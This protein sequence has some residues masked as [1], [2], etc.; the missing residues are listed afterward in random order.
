MNTD[1]KFYK[2]L[3][4]LDKGDLGQGE[5]LLNEIVLESEKEGDYINLIRGLV[6][7]ADFQ[8]SQGKFIEARNL[9]NKVINSSNIDL[10]DLLDFEH[11]RA[12]ELLNL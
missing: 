4:L 12:K 1:Q 9:L 5:L 6:C 2:A 10:D 8:Y 7:L 11:N 3:L